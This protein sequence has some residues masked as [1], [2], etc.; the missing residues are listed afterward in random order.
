MQRLESD[1]LR[2]QHRFFRDPKTEKFGC[3]L[4]LN[5]LHNHGVFGDG[6]V[7]LGKFYDLYIRANPFEIHSNRLPH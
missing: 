7:P 6:K 1:A 2:L 4:L 5:R 3:T